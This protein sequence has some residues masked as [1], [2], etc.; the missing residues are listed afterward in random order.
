[1]KKLRALLPVSALLFA[2]VF[3]IV[4]SSYRNIN[5]ALKS[6]A[7]AKNYKMTVQKQRSV[8]NAIAFKEFKRLTGSTTYMVNAAMGEVLA[9]LVGIITLV[10]GAVCAVLLAGMKEL[11]NK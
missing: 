3:W 2:A 5:S 9:V 11:F 1:M 10:I 8:V 7:S 4:G 6:H